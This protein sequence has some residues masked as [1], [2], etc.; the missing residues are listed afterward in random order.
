MGCLSEP[1]RFLNRE[2][3]G[4]IHLTALEILAT[5][6]MK[7]DHIEALEYLENVGCKVNW[8]KRVVKIPED[9]TQKY[10]DKMKSDYRKD[11]RIPQEMRVRYSQIRFRREKFKIHHEF[12]VNTGGFCPFIYDLN[13]NRREATIKDVRDAIKLVNHLDNITYTGLPCVA[14][15][16]PAVLRPV[17]MAAELVKWTRK[18]GGIETFNKFDVKYITQIAEI[19][20]GGKEELRRDPIL[21]GYAEARSPLC[22]DHNMVDIFVEYIKKGFPQILDTM[23]NAGAT[24]PINPAGTLAL[25]LAETLCGV[26]LAYAI[27]NNAIVGVDVTPSFSDMETGIFRYAGAER[28]ALLG[29]RIQMISEYYGCPSGVHGGKTDSCFYG[30][31]TGVEKTAS[32]MIPILCGAIGIGTV[33]HL[34]NAVTFSPLQLVMDNEIIGYVRWSLKGFTVDE[35]SLSLETIKEVGIG[36]IYLS[37]ENTLRNFRASMLLSPFF[38]ALP[39]ASARDN[40]QGYMEKR[41]REKTE[42]ILSKEMEPVLTPLQIKEI[43]AVVIAA[44][45]E[46]RREGKM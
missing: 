43:D 4:K 2:E 14:Q 30:T 8:K 16:I 24:G 6:G 39:W 35:K 11:N 21:I 27:D 10:V 25:G 5:V 17:A 3:M 38:Q 44:G 1:I 29:A 9:I 28:W 41:A 31:R 34:E 32:I 33:G 22:F 13:N 19:V 20:A 12:S 46:L 7:V 18:L 42:R 40:N 36:G 26:V 15:E 23:T 45:K 37:H